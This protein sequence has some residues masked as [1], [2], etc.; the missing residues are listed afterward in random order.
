[1]ETALTSTSMDRAP[2]PPASFV[3]GK[4]GYVPFKPGGLDDILLSSTQDGLSDER[5]KGL[6]TIPPGLSR[7]LRLVSDESEDEVLEALEESL[8]PVATQSGIF[9]V[10]PLPLLFLTIA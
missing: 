8:Y 7:G 3:R 1:M 10:I 9:V 6:R 2:A 4:S 5:T